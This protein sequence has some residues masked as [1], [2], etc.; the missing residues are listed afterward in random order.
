M[1]KSGFSL[2]L[3]LWIV[4]IMSLAAALYLGYA[5]KVVTKSRQLN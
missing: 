2:A 1:K 5:K 4:A 3:T